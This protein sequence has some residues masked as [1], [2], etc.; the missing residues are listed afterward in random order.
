MDNSRELDMEGIISS[1][2]CQYEEIAQKSKDEVNT[3]YE[4]KVKSRGQGKAACTLR[5]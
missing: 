2:K 3:L 1:V 4:N 5:K